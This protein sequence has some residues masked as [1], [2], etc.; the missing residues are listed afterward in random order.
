MHVYNSKGGEH[1]EHNANAVIQ[2]HKLKLIPDIQY[3][4][5]QPNYPYPSISPNYIPQIRCLSSI[6]AN[7][8]EAFLIPK[9]KDYDVDFQSFYAPPVQLGT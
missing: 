9:W 5:P 4:L 6:I 7:K 3:I 8:I 1:M 2:N